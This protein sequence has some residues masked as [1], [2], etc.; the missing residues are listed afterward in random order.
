MTLLVVKLSTAITRARDFSIKHLKKNPTTTN[1]T[2]F[3][4]HA[5]LSDEPFE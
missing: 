1:R 3:K 2:F 4:A 5:N